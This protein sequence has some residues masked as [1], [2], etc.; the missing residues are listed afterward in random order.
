MGRCLPDTPMPDVKPLPVRRLPSF[1]AGM[2]HVGKAAWLTNAHLARDFN[3][4][5]SMLAASKRAATPKPTAQE[6]SAAMEKRKLF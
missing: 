5:C 1:W 3:E 2:S 4:A 6:Y